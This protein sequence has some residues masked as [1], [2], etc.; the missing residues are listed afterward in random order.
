MLEVPDFFYESLSC[1][2]IFEV[3]M[4]ESLLESFTSSSM[5]RRN[6]LFC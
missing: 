4:F 3:F 1:P 2:F 6:F 5:K